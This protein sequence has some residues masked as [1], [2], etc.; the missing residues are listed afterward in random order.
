MPA[1]HIDEDMAQGLTLVRLNGSGRFLGSVPVSPDMARHGNASLTG[2]Q[3]FSNTAGDRD[4][5]LPQSGKH[6][7]TKGERVFHQKFGRHN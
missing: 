1:L 2:R 3:A 5:W 7:F 4:G 6:D